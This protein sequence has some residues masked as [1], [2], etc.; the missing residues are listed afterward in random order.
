MDDNPVILYDGIC[1][2]CADSVQFVIRRDPQQRFRFARLQSK[3]AH[4]ILANY[5]ATDNDLDSVILIY[6]GRLY[7]KSRAALHIARLL[8]GAWPLLGLFL[9][10]PRFIADPVYDY[11]GRHRYHW[12][13]RQASCSVPDPE[14]RWRFLDSREDTVIFELEY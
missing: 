10:V 14:Q 6:Q 11:I 3:T 2:L 12:F 9:L 7:R 1:H 5:H 13:G 8:S 4:R